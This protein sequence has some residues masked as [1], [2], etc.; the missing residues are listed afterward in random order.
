MGFK[1]K[2]NLLTYCMTGIVG[3]GLMT[4]PASA[5]DGVINEDNLK[6]MESFPHI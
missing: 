4:S 6:A 2:S 5:V 3:V 1:L